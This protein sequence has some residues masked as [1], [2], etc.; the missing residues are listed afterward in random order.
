MNLVDP[1]ASA[2]ITN[3]ILLFHKSQ[4]K[5]FKIINIIDPDLLKE[6]YPPKLKN[7]KRI[8]HFISNKL[9]SHEESFVEDYKRKILSNGFSFLQF[10]E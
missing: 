7:D 1:N 10:L 9:G 8:S 5:D 3:A 6:F 2:W 4:N